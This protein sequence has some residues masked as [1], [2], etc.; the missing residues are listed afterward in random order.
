MRQNLTPKVEMGGIYYP[1]WFGSGIH[2][3][4][5]QYYRP[6]LKRDPVEAFISWYMLQL[7]GGIVIEEQLD[8][9]HDRQP[10]ARGDST[11][12]VR[13]LIELLPDPNMEEFE[14]HKELGIGM[15][16]YYKEYAEANDN[17]EV[18]VEEHTFSVPIYGPDGNILEAIDPRDGKVKQVHLRGT[19]DAIIQD[20]ENGQFGILEHKSAIAIGEDYHRKLEQD[21]QCTTYMVAAET[22]ANIHDLEYEKIDFTLYNALRKAFPRP[23]TELKSGLFSTNRQTESTTI[24]MLD[25]FIDERGLRNLVE[26]TPKMS[27]YYNY[28]KDIGDKQFIERTPVR[29][30]RYELA[31]AKKLIYLEALDMLSEPR[32]YP[33]KS[34]NWLCLN[35]PFRAPCL[36]TDD[37]SDALMLLEDNY[38]SNWTR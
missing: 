3:A 36:A 6:G 19:Q 12:Y 22:E 33:T 37:G 21:E 5:A 16:T 32:I 23:P 1:L 24:Q 14:I 8:Q 9:T 38:E 20:L 2:Y 26:E 11:F 10:M 13:G 28:V 35:C 7:D 29:R 30:N 34:G 27:E 31:A 4:L 25:T 17:F 15:L 18:I